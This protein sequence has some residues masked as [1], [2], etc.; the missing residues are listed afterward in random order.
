VPLKLKLWL[1]RITDW[2]KD[3]VRLLLFILV[4]NLA[5]FGAIAIDQVRPF[6]RSDDCNAECKA[7]VE[8]LTDRLIEQHFRDPDRVIDDALRDAR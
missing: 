4:I 6:G 2:D 8:R 7:E 1:G 5:I 3:S